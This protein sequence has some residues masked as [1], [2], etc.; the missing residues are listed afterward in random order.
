MRTDLID[1]SQTAFTARDN[2]SVLPAGWHWCVSHLSWYQ[3]GA[4]AALSGES[5]WSPPLC[6]GPAASDRDRRPDTEQR[7]PATD[8]QTRSTP[9]DLNV[10]EDRREPTDRWDSQVSHNTRVRGD[11][12][13]SLKWTFAADSITVLKQRKLL[14]SGRLIKSVEHLLVPLKVTS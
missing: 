10:T 7:P 12:L 1:T 8:S 2:K 13:T 9:T 4:P 11:S 6:W 3:V 14:T 5:L